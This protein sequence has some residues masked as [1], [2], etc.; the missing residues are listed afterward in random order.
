[1]KL[2]RMRPEHETRTGFSRQGRQAR[3]GR[4]LERRS[5]PSPDLP[6]DVPSETREAVYGPPAAQDSLFLKK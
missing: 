4:L 3:Q 2:R 6:S 5:T 1:M